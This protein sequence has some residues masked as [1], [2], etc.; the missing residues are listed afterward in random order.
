MEALAIDVMFNKLLFGE[1]EEEVFWLTHLFMKLYK[2]GVECDNCVDMFVRENFKSSSSSLSLSS[3]LLSSL[4]KG[5]GE[6]P[7]RY[8]GT[9]LGASKCL[10]ECGNK[11]LKL[12][13]AWKQVITL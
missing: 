6:R 13:N 5:L 3:S 2:L 11:R 8:M 10:A 1:V 9:G 12:E 7:G 4:L